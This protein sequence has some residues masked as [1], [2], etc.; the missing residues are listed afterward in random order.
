MY[1]T[2]NDFLSKALTSITSGIISINA[3]E[4]FNLGIYG[5]YI[6]LL[7]IYYIISSKFFSFKFKKKYF[8][9]STSNIFVSLQ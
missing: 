8:I 7:P 4:I 1:N 5:N 3:A 6:A 9:I 2:L